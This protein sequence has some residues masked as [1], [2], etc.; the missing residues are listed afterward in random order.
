MTVQVDRIQ[1]PLFDDKKLSL[2]IKLTQLVHMLKK[3]KKK[4]KEKKKKKNLT[5]SYTSF[6]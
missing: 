5:Y 6:F 3:K 1:N 2:L 4:K